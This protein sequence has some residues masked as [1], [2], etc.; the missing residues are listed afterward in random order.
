MSR[1]N[2]ALALSFSL[3]APFFAVG[4]GPDAKDKRISELTKENDQLKAELADRDSKVN[5]LT[6]KD[7]EAQKAVRDLNKEL[8]DARDRL[9]KGTTAAPPAIGETATAAAPP[10]KGWVNMPGFDMIS[11]PGEVLFDSGK[12]TLRPTGKSTLDKLASDIRSR[13]AD[14]DIYV[15]GNTDD[16]PIR[17]SGWKD[18]WQLGAERSL[19]AVRYLVQAGIPPSKVIQ[20]NCSEYRPRAIGKANGSRKE[21][22]RVDFYAVIKHTGG[23]MELGSTSP[24]AGASKI[25]AR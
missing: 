14:R 19:T 8:A 23:G 22:R 3:L 18:N 13:Y 17:K 2:L 15:F 1:M 20:A 7:E 10:S 16:E 6:A 24:T 4:C 9:A 21:N 5:D 25:A 12:A 11:I